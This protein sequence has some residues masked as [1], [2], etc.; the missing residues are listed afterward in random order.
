MNTKIINML[1]QNPHSCGVNMRGNRKTGGNN[2]TKKHQKSARGK[3]QSLNAN[4][5]PKQNEKT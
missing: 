4:K 3:K 5:L 1:K 2:N